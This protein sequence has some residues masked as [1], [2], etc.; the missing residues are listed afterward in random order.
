MST[1]K[2]V[3]PLQKGTLS[4]WVFVTLAQ[5]REEI[6]SR[7]VK[8]RLP[9]Y[10]DETDAVPTLL[11]AGKRGSYFASRPHPQGSRGQLLW[12]ITPKG[13]ARLDAAVEQ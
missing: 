10:I 7:Q 12:S 4:Y 13:K 9:N 2:G 1:T 5:S 8:E 11:T 6:T 3:R